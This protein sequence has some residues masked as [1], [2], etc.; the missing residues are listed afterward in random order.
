MTPGI[1]FASKSIFSVTA[2]SLVP[3]M[4]ARRD[5]NDQKNDPRSYGLALPSTG[6]C[7]DQHPAEKEWQQ[8]AATAYVRS[9]FSSIWQRN[10][11]AS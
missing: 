8:N 7:A 9:H 10:I 4:R 6:L 3:D 11:K 2:I 5:I 1:S